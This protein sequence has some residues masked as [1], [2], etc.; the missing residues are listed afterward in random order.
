MPERALPSLVT[1]LTR[2]ATCSPNCSLMSFRVTEVS[3]TTSCKTAAMMVSSSIPQDLTISMTARG[4]V[5]YGSP[6]FLN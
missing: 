4:W 1:P 3:S 5:I 6:D 2:K